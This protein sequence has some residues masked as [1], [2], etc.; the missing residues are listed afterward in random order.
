[1]F[2]TGEHNCADAFRNSTGYKMMFHRWDEVDQ[3]ED[4]ERGFDRARGYPV[5]TSDIDL[6]LFEEAYTSKD[7]LVRIYKVK[8]RPNKAK[9]FT[10]IPSRSYFIPEEPDG[11]YQFWQPTI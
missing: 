5:R 6:T 7:W 11:E 9:R 3:G 10:A 2:G 8:D 4:I 1:M